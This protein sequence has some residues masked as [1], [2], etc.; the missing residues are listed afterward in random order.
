[1]QFM[2]QSMGWA[3]NIVLAMAPLG[4]ITTVVSAIRVGGPSWLKALVGRARENLAV[5]E[6]DLMSST[7]N[8]VC[9]L[10]N[11]R[12]VVRCMGSAPVVEFICL[13]PPGGLEKGSKTQPD[14]EIIDFK[15]AMRRG[16]LTEIGCPSKDQE[17]EPRIPKVAIIGKK[18]DSVSAAPNISLN[19][20]S[21]FWRGELRAIAVFGIII[22]LGVLA[23]SGLAAYYPTWKFQKANNPI[24]GYAYPCTSIG[25]LVMVAGIL[26]CAHVVEGSTVEKRYQA[27]NGRQARLVW[28]Q[29]TKT[30]SDQFF[31]SFAI[32]A[33]DDRTV[34]TTSHQD[35]VTISADDKISISESDTISSQRHA[36]LPDT[37]YERPQSDRVL[38]SSPQ[39]DPKRPERPESLEEKPR[40]DRVPSS[41]SQ[42]DTQRPESLDEMT[43]SQM[44]TRRTTSRGRLL[45]R[46]SRV[47]RVQ[48]KAAGMTDRRITP[49]AAGDPDCGVSS[50]Q[51]DT[52][53]KTTGEQDVNT[54]LATKAVLGT[55]V[56]LGGFIIQFIGLRAM[57]WSASVA[58]LGAVIVMT[59]FRAWVRRGLA[60][61]PRCERLSPGFELEWFA[62]TL[63]DVG[64]APWLAAPKSKEDPTRAP[65]SGK[66][67]MKDWYIV[68]GGSPGVHQKLGD[69]TGGDSPK[70]QTEINSDA[71]KAQTVIDNDTSEEQT[72]KNNDTLKE[73][74]VNSNVRSKAQTVMELMRDIA[75]YAGSDSQSIHLRLRKREGHWKV[76]SDEINAVLSLW[77]YSAYGLERDRG[78][79]Q[80]RKEAVRGRHRHKDEDEWLREEGSREKGSLRLLGSTSR[81]LRRD[82]QWW[83]PRG[84][85]RVIEVKEA[86]DNED[87]DNADNKEN[88]AVKLEVQNHRIV[89]CGSNSNRSQHLDGRTRYNS[90]EM[91]T[92]F[93]SEDMQAGDGETENTLLATESQD[94]LQ[95]VFAQDI[96]SAFMWAMAKTMLPI[97]DECE[98]RPDGT[99]GHDGW[100]LFTL[101]GDKLSKM[102]H[103]IQNT[104]LGS[105]DQVYLSI[106]PPLSVQH[107]LPRVEA[108]IDLARQQAR[109]H[110]RL[111]QWRVAGD[112]FSHKSLG[113]QLAVAK[114]IHNWTVLHYAAVSGDSAIINWLLKYEP[115][116]INA[117]D[118]TEWTPLHYACER[119]NELV[120]KDLIQKG[121][122][123]DTHGRDGIAPLH[124]A[125][126]KGHRKVVRTLI[127]AGADIDVLDASRHTPLLWAAYRGHTT[128]VDEL[129]KD[130]N[131]KLRGHSGLTAMHLAVIGGGEEVVRLL[132]K[133]G[134]DMDVKDHFG[135]TPLHHATK[136][137]NE[138]MVRI[139]IE[140]GV[141]KD[142][143]DNKGQT[144]LHYAARD[145]LKAMVGLL[146]ELGA[147]KEAQKRYKS[148]TPLYYV[149]ENGHEDVV[150]LLIELGVNKEAKGYHGW[151]P[152]IYAAQRGLGA[153]VRL[154]IDLGA[155]KD[156]KGIDGRTPLHQAAW[157]G[158][159]AVVRILIELGADKDTKD[160]S[161]GTPLRN[162]ALTEH[163]AVV[164]I[165][166]ELGADKDAKDNSGETPLRQAARRGNK[167]VVRI[168]IELGAD[169]N[170]EDKR[171]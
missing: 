100:K 103:D 71:S 155:D 63:G 20:H 139:L 138:T 96:F 60:K 47:P 91:P 69:V 154:L 104:G 52:Q 144:P 13:L 86:K 9:E 106:I 65:K 38:G 143:M 101:W 149:I 135:R 127:E 50:F 42:K 87:K 70:A 170:A 134:A 98:I 40:S 112:D 21:Y 108:I 76:Y 49:A 43:S 152:L 136:N 94:S 72:A 23:Y 167:D 142:T 164:R 84:I 162:A 161:D 113:I 77:L 5:A 36:Q 107:R 158:H 157:A 41:S 148:R 10:W 57:H 169:M 146:I 90:W 39:G 66:P 150:R 153:M 62:T 19:C 37:L 163:E 128:V 145:G 33:E 168:L 116:Y 125:A 140:F 17:Q 1:M 110:E 130:A 64:G 123:L 126:M 129:W 15:T 11:G 141:D 166:I 28:L 48:G 171:G 81:A 18:M 54:L 22:Q 88:E 4:I 85:A 79:E 119:N 133:L 122:G 3:D 45:Q 99:G 59:T 30:V 46:L 165:L 31:D 56:G 53:R 115:Y 82:L 29:Q 131:I 124:N 105:L 55:L 117:Q 151:T 118:L 102:V 83:I 147:D 16:D 132:V 6:A 89:G 14:I 121:A 2:S 68:T 114:D 35:K 95:M 32:F 58:Q 61:P 27:G 25:T 109:Q 75:R 156:A 12:Q 111:Q 97:E 93:D 159:E 160:K 120:V 78:Q 137:G 51:S 34:I 80:Q 73:Q 7:S 26:L 74:R 67:V 24:A 44:V 92:R 8:E